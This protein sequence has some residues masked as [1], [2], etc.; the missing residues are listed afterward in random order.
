M[1]DAEEIQALTRRIQQKV[2]SNLKSES[3]PEGTLQNC[4]TDYN[5]CF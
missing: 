5:K 1:K 4:E 2:R 3:N